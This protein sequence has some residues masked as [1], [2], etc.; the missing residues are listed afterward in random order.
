VFHPAQTE[1]RPRQS[2]TERNTFCLWAGFIW[3]MI[4]P[5]MGSCEYG[6]ELPDFRDHTTEQG[7][8][9]RQRFTLVFGRYWVR[10]WARTRCILSEVFAVFLKP[11]RQYQDSISTGSR[12]LPSKSFPIHRLRIILSFDAAVC[13]NERAL[14]SV[15]PPTAIIR[16]VKLSDRRRPDRH[17]FQK[18]GRRAA[19]LAV[20]VST[21][22]TA[23][24]LQDMRCIPTGVNEQLL[25]E[26]PL[27]GVTTQR[28][29]I[30]FTSHFHAQWISSG[31]GSS[32]NSLSTTGKRDAQAQPP[33]WPHLF[34]H[35]FWALGEGTTFRRSISPP[36]SGSSC[37]CL[38][39]YSSKLEDGGGIF[40][41]YVE[42]SPD[43]TASQPSRPY[44]S[45]LLP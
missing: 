22:E 29:L 19:N 35:E 44:A 41:L 24:V 27:R 26:V 8:V 3:H 14:C 45:Q 37:T 18:P 32:S 33:F 20:D 30:L 38:I 1:L 28:S 39:E 9:Q 15:E 17:I 21:R 7:S 23:A 36:S 4:C 2:F 34:V 43:Y 13:D 42:F 25:K 6:D 31:G 5:A 12:S 10:I 11:S 16:N 40:L